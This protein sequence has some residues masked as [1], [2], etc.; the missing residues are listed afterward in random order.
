MQ[1][2]GKSVTGC[3]DIGGRREERE[4]EGVWRC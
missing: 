3:G 1:G 2:Q 4:C